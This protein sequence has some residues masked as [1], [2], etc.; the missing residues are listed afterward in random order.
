MLL[1]VEYILSFWPCI[2]LFHQAVFH[3]HLCGVVED[4]GETLLTHTSHTLI[5]AG[6]WD[7]VR[8]PRRVPIG[9]GN[10]RILPGLAL[11]TAARHSLALCNNEK[12]RLL[13]S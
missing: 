9:T 6:I 10:P 12:L 8:G 2:G 1:C 7:A 3:S 11:A 13:R 5:S 4:K